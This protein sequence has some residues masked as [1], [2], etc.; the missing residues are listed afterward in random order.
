M[1]TLFFILLNTF[2]GF[3][4]ASAPGFQ[5]LGQPQTYASSLLLF[6]SQ[7]RQ[8]ASLPPYPQIAALSS[9]RGAGA[10]LPG[11]QLTSITPLSPYL[12]KK[13]TLFILN[14]T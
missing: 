2:Y 8:L 10:L 11:L 12:K 14:K 5:G 4:M 13:K 1:E 9:L 6:H 7:C 3:L